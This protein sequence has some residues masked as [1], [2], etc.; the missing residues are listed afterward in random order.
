MAILYLGTAV[1][2]GAYLFYNYGLHHV[3][4][5]QATAYGNLISVIDIGLGHIILSEYLTLLQ[6]AAFSLVIAGAW[7][8]QRRSNKETAEPSP[9]ETQL[10]IAL[11]NQ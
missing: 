10:N 8:S 2:F 9:V 11:E 4:A 6:Y 7:M 3:P 1:S 5:A